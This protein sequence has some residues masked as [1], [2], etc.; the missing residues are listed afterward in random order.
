MNE[1]EI[2]EIRRRFR[3][4]KNNI[5]R[6]CGCY[7]NEKGEV[8][9]QFDQPLALTPQEDCERMLAL[10]KK[11]L[12]GTLGKNLFDISFSTQQV[13][14]SDE[15]RLLMALRGC[16]LNDPEV[17]QNFYSRMISAISL[18]SHYL[19]LLAYDTY[20]VPYRSKDGEKLEDASSEVYSYILCSV[21][22]VKPEKP[23]LCFDIPENTMR[24][25]REEWLIAAPELGFLFPAFDDRSTNIYNALFYS[26][27]TED[28]HASFIDAVFRADPPVP[29]A[30]QKEA[31]SSL[32]GDT[33]N[34]D[35]SYEMVQAVNEQLCGM[36]QEHKESKQEEPLSLTKATVKNVLQACG[37]TEQQVDAFDENY[38]TV[39]GA[40]AQIS[41]SNLVEK[42][43][44]QV[45]TPDVTI[46]VNAE[47]GDL[48][49]TRVIDG[50]KYIL[51]RAGENVTVNGIGIHIS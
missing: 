34:E 11:S 29:A 35:C 20:D 8:I 19:I 30:V 36:I 23:A 15:H 50:V 28:N 10:L 25:I 41:P 39:F 22:P 44:L 48:V 7:V 40:D 14:D 2:A 4:D 33:L 17:V 16:A 32:L 5:T 26:R 37:A 18:D 45:R 24:N 12:S 46:Q 47:H 43:Q 21:C 31:F 51:I 3:P 9:S 1:K 49:Q 27:N 42:K 38:N 13:V 6:I